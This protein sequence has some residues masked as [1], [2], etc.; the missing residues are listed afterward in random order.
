MLILHGSLFIGK[1]FVIRDD[2][3]HIVST[4]FVSLFVVIDIKFYELFNM[5]PIYFFDICDSDIVPQ[6]RDLY[7]K[8]L[9]QLGSWPCKH[10]IA[11]TIFSNLKI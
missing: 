2:G 5:P 8:L 10:D 6:T 7:S 11:S 9:H 1:L 3:V 4:D